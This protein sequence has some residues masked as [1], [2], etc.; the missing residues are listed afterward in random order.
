M[1]ELGLL[2]VVVFTVGWLIRPRKSVPLS[3]LVIDNSYYHLTLDPVLSEEQSMF[4]EVAAGYAALQLPA[5]NVATQYFQI[6]PSA[7]NSSSPSVYLLAMSVRHGKLYFQAIRPTP[8]SLANELLLPQIRQFAEAV[9]VNLPIGG[10]SDTPMQFGAQEI[11][12]AIARQ[13]HRDL[14]QL[15]Q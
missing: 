13:R 8:I 3:P 11:L 1:F 5:K 9:M 15:S 10:D 6:R 12:R 7:E 2:I 4:D 14:L